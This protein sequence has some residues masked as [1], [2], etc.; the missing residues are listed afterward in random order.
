MKTRRMHGFM[1]AGVAL[2]LLAAVAA[3]C[4]GSAGIED[5]SSD[6]ASAAPADAGDSGAVTA[7]MIVSEAVRDQTHPAELSTPAAP[8]GSSA[9]ASEAPF[10]MSGEATRTWATTSGTDPSSPTGSTEILTPVPSETPATKG[11]GM[12]PS[13]DDL[14]DL[15]Q[16]NAAFAYN[17]YRELS[18]TDGNLFFAPHSISTALAMTYAGA[19]GGTESAMAETLRFPIPPESLHGAFES[20]AHTLGTRS[21]GEDRAGFRLNA[22]N[23]VWAQD[24]HPFRDAYLDVVKASYGGEVSLADF[25]G[26]P[27]GSRS[28]I[29]GWVERRT[30]GNIKDLIP[31]DLIDGLTR[32]VLVNAVY[33]KAGWLQPFDEHLTSRE[34]FYLLDGGTTDVDMMRATEHFGYGAG[35]GYQVVDLP[36]VGGELSMTLLLPEQGRFREFEERLD[37]GLV[38]QALAQVSESYVALEM[39][40][41]EFIA[42]FRLGETLKDMGMSAAFDA[43]AADFSGMD[44]LS[45]AAGDHGCLYIG[46]VV[47][48]AFV[49]VDEAGTEA[50]AATGVVMQTESAKPSPVELRV[51]RPFIFMVRDRPTG[52]V[53]F[54]GRVLKP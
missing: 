22:A 3:G 50:A 21:A 42:A 46:D 20:L 45:C 37:G 38:A 14:G 13:G 53:L 33:F 51:D 52:T 39:P 41:F 5:L 27:D 31:P 17:L 25:A 12:R 26:D 48:K 4:G 34:S 16:A 32:M 35:D 18:T 29:N 54:V 28:Q 7:D 19:G 11:P 40:R 24:R 15:T 1:T 36:Y 9:P 43:S 10:V 49:S 47:H 23:A 2:V 6:Q 30:E 44:G 8:A